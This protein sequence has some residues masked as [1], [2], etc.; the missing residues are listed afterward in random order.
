L[1]VELPCEESRT[2]EAMVAGGATN[3][4]EPTN[5]VAKA[6]LRQLAETRYV[7]S[8]IVVELRSWELFEEEVMRDSRTF[9][10]VTPPAAIADLRRKA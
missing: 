6:D 3:G 4:L 8:G 1:D 10:S 7:E 2:I 5:S 9:C